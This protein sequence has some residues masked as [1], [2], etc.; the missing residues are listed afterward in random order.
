MAATGVVVI[1]EAAITEAGITAIIM[2]D[3]AGAGPWVVWPSAPSLAALWRSP[4]TARI[5]A[6]P[7]A[8]ARPTAITGRLIA[9]TVRRIATM[10]RPTAIMAGPIG[11]MH[12][13]P[14]M[15]EAA[16]TRAGAMRAIVRTGLTTIPSSLITD[17]VASASVPIDWQVTHLRRELLPFERHVGVAPQPKLGLGSITSSDFHSTSRWAGLQG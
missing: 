7:T 11:L 6:H 3:R 13:L 15:E 4:I 8:T 2:V 5:T 1:M 10:A 16:T 17:P 12:R 9:I 14:I